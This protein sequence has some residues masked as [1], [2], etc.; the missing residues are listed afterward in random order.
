MKKKID[1]YRSRAERQYLSFKFVFLL[2]KM[3]E[4]LEVRGTTSSNTVHGY[5]EILL[6]ES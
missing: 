2:L 1:N 3:N 4:K 6:P 5:F